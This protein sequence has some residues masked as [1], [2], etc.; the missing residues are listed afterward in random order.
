LNNLIIQTVE[1]ELRK[2]R[3]AGSARG[4]IWMAAD[5]DEPLEDFKDYM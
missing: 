1:P 5:F 4:E 2:R 3:Q